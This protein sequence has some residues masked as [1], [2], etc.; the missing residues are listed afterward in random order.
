MRPRAAFVGMVVA[1]LAALT[2]CGGGNN[3]A[4]PILQSIAVTGANSTLTLASPPATQQL[5][6]TGTFN[7]NAQK[8]LTQLVTWS[9]S[10][11][12]VATVSSTG[13]L[14]AIGSGTATVSATLQG[15]SGQAAFTV[16]A[17]L[18]SISVTPAGSTL[19]L[20]TAPLPATTQQFVALGGYNDGSTKNLS[21]QVSW[22]SASPAVATINSAGLA[23]TVAPGTTSIQASLGQITGSTT[24]TVKAQLLSIAVSSPVSKMAPGTKVQLT[25]TG[26]YNDG[27]KVDLTNSALWS[28]SNTAVA[29]VSS[30]T[31]SAATVTALSQG[32]VTITATMGTG[33][34]AVSGGVQLTVSSAQIVSLAIAPPTATFGI[35]LLQKYVATGTFDDGSTQ[36]L[37]NVAT[38]SLGTAN[39][40]KV[41]GNGYFTGAGVGSSTVTATWNQVTGSAQAIV[42]AS[43][44][45]VLAVSPATAQI[46]QHTTQSFRALATLT[47][48]STLDVSSAPGIVWTSSDHSVATV[49]SSGTATGLPPATSSASATIQAQLGSSPSAP[50]GAA[51]L[52]VTN[53]L[54]AAIAVGPANLTTQ[55]GS[56]TGY[57]A[58]GVF[59]DGT[60]QNV[61]QLSTWTSSDTTVATLYGST[62]TC[63][64]KGGVASIQASFQSVAGSTTLICTSAA[65]TSI[66][67]SPASA[68]VSVLGPINTVQLE[69]TALFN[70]VSQ[71][72]TNGVTWSSSDDTV[73]S[74]SP[75]G[76]A[77]AVGVGSATVTANIAADGLTATAT[78]TVTSSP[79]VSLQ[80]TPASASIANTT[81]YQFNAIGNFADGSTQN[82]TRL[83][84]WSSSD[85]A[86]ATV[87]NSG[88]IGYALSSAAGSTQI[89]AQSNGINSSAATLVVTG[90]TLQ[91]ITI[92]PQNP[93]VG[94]G[95]AESF[96]ATG[97]FSDGTTQDVTSLASWTSSAPQVMFF[98]SSNTGRS[99]G[100]GT[101]TVTAT[102]DGVSGTTGVTVQ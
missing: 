49:S 20:A 40:A 89:A 1:L 65:P 60:S 33:S 97:H 53:A 19:L 46:A 82:L 36:D 45:T 17:T 102:F 3:A 54:P 42:D 14:T 62:A 15:V 29:T 70:G 74:V 94:L 81:G 58:I 61:T 11:T 32:T 12:S 26:S 101:A 90:A 55:A 30:S 47:D 44:L 4:V 48:G 69:V 21:T 6:A 27:T 64:P 86:V 31:T 91:A 80:V 68:Q 59:N 22:T 76:L 35:G 24:L 67:I 52:V 79:L 87:S 56:A 41:N 50:T 43:S 85:P 39:V 98:S 75:S 28:S 16:V 88:T 72:V 95:G 100:T 78:V 73:V 8:D 77:T 9:S 2:A 99:S 66:A 25:A 92:N 18:T 10:N 5:A 51:S 71:T 34:S 63:T 38:W 96:S 57:T 83:A 84:H 23:T 13:M 37:S 93:T 7:N